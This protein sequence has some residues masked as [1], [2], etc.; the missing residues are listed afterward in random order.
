MTSHEVAV[1][2]LLV[3]AVISPE[4]SAGAGGV[5][6]LWL[7]PGPDPSPLGL[8]REQPRDTEASVRARKTEATVFL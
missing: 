3:R 2:K 4:G 8:S 1:K 6:V 7:L 5:C